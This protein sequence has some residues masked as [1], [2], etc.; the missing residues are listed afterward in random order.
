MM[1]ISKH[2]TLLRLCMIHNLPEGLGITLSNPPA[3]L[4]LR[5]LLLQYPSAMKISPVEATA[6]E[7]GLHKWPWSDPGTKSSPKT[8]VGIFSPRLN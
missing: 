1:Q 7:V 8:K 2:E 5:I 3:A 6:I 4:Y